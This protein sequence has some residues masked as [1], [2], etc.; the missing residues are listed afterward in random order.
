MPVREAPASSNPFAVLSHRARTQWYILPNG[1]TA[2]SYEA[3]EGM[4]QR[5][6]FSSGGADAAGLWGAA[7]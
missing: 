3:A 7:A 2:R 6:P 4:G 1:C 5:R